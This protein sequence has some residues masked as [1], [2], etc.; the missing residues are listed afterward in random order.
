M[1]RRHKLAMA[2][3]RQGV[4]G[5]GL[6]RVHDRVLDSYQDI[7]AGTPADRALRKRLRSARDLGASERRTLSDAVYRMVRGRRWA[8]ER[9]RRGFRAASGPAWAR[10]DDMMKARLCYLLAEVD[11]GVAWPAIEKMDPAVWRRYGSILKRAAAYALDAVKDEAKRVS[12]RHSFPDWVTEALQAHYSLEAIDQIGT[13]L[14]TR[15]PV[16]LRVHPGR[17]TVAEACERLQADGV[18]ARP[19]RW[20]LNGLVVS[21]DQDLRSHPLVADGTLEFQDEGSQLIACAV[22]PVAGMHIL[23][24]C[25]GAGGKTVYLAAL[26]EG[27]GQVDAVDR[28][29]RKEMPLKERAR[30]AGLTN[31][32]AR[33]A[34]VLDPS[35]CPGPYDR[36][37]V[38]APCTGSGVLRRRPDALWRIGPA[39]VA[40]HQARQQ[41]MLASAAARTKV[42]G[43]LVYATC[44]ILPAENEAVSDAFLAATEHFAPRPLA[45]AWG[46]ARADRLGATHEARIGPGPAPWGPDGFYVATF[47]RVR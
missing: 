26:M 4:V 37:L 10:V 15:A 3:R 13:V 25:A 43:V 31:V 6:G 28:E 34:D 12:L 24:A 21:P 42:G 22:S 5:A 11:R 2:S 46:E 9:L 19:M 1:Q 44:S 40:A 17:M 35:V 39:D 14:A 7:L 20:A 30:R 38:D 47:E 27:T 18:P 45:L 33:T 16:G 36:V 32:H 8:E 41:Q 29:A 23:D